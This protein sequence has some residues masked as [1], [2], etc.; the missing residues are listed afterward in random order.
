[1]E[2]RHV[3]RERLISKVSMKIVPPKGSQLKVAVV[4]VEPPEAGGAHNAERLM[5]EQIRQSLDPHELIILDTRKAPL[6]V[7]AMFSR[8]AGYIRSLLAIWKTNPL[9]WAI[10]RRFSWISSTAFEREL[11]RKSVDLV[12]F[13]GPYDRALELK[14][15]PFVATI[16]DL[17][18]RDLPALPELVANREF[19]YREWRMRHVATKALAIVVDS[20]PTKEKLK[21]FYGISDSK[22]HSLPFAPNVPENSGSGERGSFALYPAHF[23]SHKNHVVL[24]EAIALLVRDGRQPRQLKL[25]GL[26]RGNLAY[27]RAKILELGIAKYVQFVGFLPEVEI[28]TLY[29]RAAVVVMPSLLGPTN[30]PPLESLLRGCP[31][32]VT[33]NARANLGDW[34]G[35]IELDGKDVNAWAQILDLN[36]ELPKVNVNQVEQ[37]LSAIGES[38]VLKLRSIFEDLRYMKSTYSS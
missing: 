6:H 20:E 28:H 15:I 7:W 5:L 36:A 32:A 9:N 10:S 11:S 4:G 30:L 38:N 26:D 19:E 14:R 31:V 23:W 34:Q 22:I 12:F 16:W 33:R 2:I 29:L 24:F 13:V 17:G 18:H 1:M 27:L 35:V 8:V 37:S 21:M 25:T 3:C